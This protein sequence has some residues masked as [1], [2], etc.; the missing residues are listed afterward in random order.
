MATPTANGG[1]VVTATATVTSAVAAATST[2]GS[3]L[4]LIYIYSTS[5]SSQPTSAASSSSSSSSSSTRLGRG[6]VAGLV[7]GS[8]AALVLLSLALFCYSRNIARKRRAEIASISP[9]RHTAPSRAYSHATTT[10]QGNVN[11]SSG[12]RAVAGGGGGGGSRNSQYARS[13]AGGGTT[14]STR[15]TAVRSV[16]SPNM[17]LPRPP[18][19]PPQELPT[20]HNRPELEGGGGGSAKD[21]GGV[22]VVYLPKEEPGVSEV[23]G[24]YAYPVELQASSM[25]DLSAVVQDM[26]RMKASGGAGRGKERRESQSNG[27]SDGYFSLGWPPPAG[28]GSETALVSDLDATTDAGE[29]TETEYGDERSI[30]IY[31]RP[32]SA[33]DTGSSPM[34]YRQSKIMQAMSHASSTKASRS[35]MRSSTTTTK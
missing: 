15:T 16:K 12:A 8:I 2:A 17:L 18:K 3:T 32:G 21:G 24:S 4:S 14:P 6:A 25:T 1:A 7:V 30:H 28:I 23:Y 27:G 31:Y 10:V 19:V 20:P 34:S 11:G 5:V 26:K 35:T 9:S 33:W 29:G 13:G 22:R